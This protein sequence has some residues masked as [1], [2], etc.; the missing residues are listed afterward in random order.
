M[1]R[2]MR[3]LVLSALLVAGAAPATAGP[4]PAVQTVVAGYDMFF[5]PNGGGRI[6]IDTGIAGVP[7]LTLRGRS[8]G[9]FDFGAKGRHRVGAADTIVRRLDTAT[10]TSPKVRIEMLALSMESTNV[11]GYFVSLQSAR[12]F[13]LPSTGTIEIAFDRTGRGGA[14]SSEVLVNY[15]VHYGSPTGPIVASGSTGMG[16]IAKDVVWMHDGRSSEKQEVCVG[17]AYCLT[18]ETAAVCHEVPVHAHCMEFRPG[19]IP[20]IKGVNHLLNGRDTSADFHPIGTG[21]RTG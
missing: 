6:G 10:P 5:T 15:D 17:T 16:F 8:L 2:S 11:P 19:P 1:P 21:I 9:S 7:M 20:L 18:V 13:G 12:P 4:R 3:F 14:V